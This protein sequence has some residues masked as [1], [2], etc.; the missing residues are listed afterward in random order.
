M[1]CKSWNYF[2]PEWPQFLVCCA[3]HKTLPKTL[4]MS[5]VVKRVCLVHVY[6]EKQWKSSDVKCKTFEKGWDMLTEMLQVQ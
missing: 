4:S 2:Q 1:F 5:T 3:M 6:I